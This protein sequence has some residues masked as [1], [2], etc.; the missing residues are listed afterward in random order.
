LPV[1]QQNAPGTVE[2]MMLAI[3]PCIVPPVSD[4]D[5][6]TL[7]AVLE[8]VPVAHVNNLVGYGFNSVAELLAFLAYD[9]RPWNY[10]GPS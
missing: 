4:R 2:S 5:A 8:R 1:K 3:V 9:V 10:K 6:K 7:R